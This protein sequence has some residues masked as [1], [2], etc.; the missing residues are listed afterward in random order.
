LLRRCIR[1][2]CCK[3]F[4]ASVWVPSG[5][6]SPGLLHGDGE[7]VA[8]KR[9]GE[10]EHGILEPL[11]A[12]AS[13]SSLHSL[14]KQLLPW[15]SELLWLP[16]YIWPP[17]R[18]IRKKGPRGNIHFLSFLFLAF[19]TAL[20]FLLSLLLFLFPLIRKLSFSQARI[21]LV[22][23]CPYHQAY[24]YNTVFRELAVSSNITRFPA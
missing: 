11:S 20:F 13:L 24:L 12:F 23:N 18:A 16:Q 7:D 15:A 5:W 8:Q 19:N 6:G 1:C 3:C 14:Q 9:G 22:F 2:I 4:L 21:S 17:I 10:G